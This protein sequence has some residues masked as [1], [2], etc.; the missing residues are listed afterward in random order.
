[1]AQKEKKKHSAM[2][3]IQSNKRKSLVSSA[4][5]TFQLPFSPGG[6]GAGKERSLALGGLGESDLKLW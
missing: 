5:K 2:F 1:M 3:I 4:V 6:A